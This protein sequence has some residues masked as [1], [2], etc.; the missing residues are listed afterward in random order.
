MR[1]RLA[2]ALALL[3]LV[4]A[5]WILIIN[6]NSVSARLQDVFA[7]SGYHN[8]PPSGSLPNVLDPT[9]FPDNPSAQVAYSLAA[10]LP[11]IL[12]QIPCACPCHKMEQ[13][14][15]L[16]DCFRTKHGEFCHACKMEAIYCFEARK[17]GLTAAAIRKE[18]IERRWTTLNLDEY[19]AAHPFSSKEIQ[20]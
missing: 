12:Y 11:E 2:P 14:Q 20:K 8:G 13:H 5:A 17:R 7:S 18:I 16:Y 6:W 19:V 15:S 9:N 1:K 4:G 10:K 3:L